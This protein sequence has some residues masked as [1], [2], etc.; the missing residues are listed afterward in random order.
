MKQVDQ[1]AR[2]GEDPR[3]NDLRSPRRISDRAE[4]DELRI[5]VRR[6]STAGCVRRRSGAVAGKISVND[7]LG[8]A[9]QYQFPPGEQEDAVAVGDEP[10][11]RV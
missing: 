11:C 9:V 2:E 1:L 5:E 6:C 4:W 7:F 8:L 3:R 10:P